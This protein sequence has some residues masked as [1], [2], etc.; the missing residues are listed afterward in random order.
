MKGG[1]SDLPSFFKSEPFGS[2]E[3]F[4]LT[5]GQDLKLPFYRGPLQS[6]E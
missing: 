5:G 1:E 6:N 4:D 3:G 2:A